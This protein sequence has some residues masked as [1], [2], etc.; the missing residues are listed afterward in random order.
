VTLVRDLYYSGSNIYF[1]GSNEI[2]KDDSFYPQLLTHELIHAFRD[3][4]ILAMDANWNY[5]PRLSGFEESFAQGVSY[6]C[7][8]RYVQLYPNDTVVNPASLYGS[9]MDWDY[10]YRNVTN[11]TTEDFW[12][13]YGGMALHWERYEMG[14]AA[15]R[16]MQLEDSGVFQKFNAAYYA[17]LNAHHTATPTRSLM[18][19]LL[20][21][22]LPQVEGIP[23]EDWINHQHIFDCRIEP[24]RKAWVRTQHYP[25][26]EYIIFQYVHYYETFSNGSDWAYY[27][28]NL[29][30]WVYYDLNGSPGNGVITDI[31]DSVIWQ[32]SKVIS[33]N[34]GGFGSVAASFTTDN[35]LAPWPGGDTADFV[36][37]MNPLGLY[38]LTF[39][40]DTTTVVVHRVIGNP[41]RGGSGI[42]GGILHSH[43][44]SV[45]IDHE[46][47]A[48]EPPISLVQGAFQGNRQW[49]SV[50]N[51]LTGGTDTKPGRL[52]VLYTDSVGNTFRTFRNIDWGSWKGNQ[53]FLFDVLE[54]QPC[55]GVEIFSNNMDDDCD[56]LTDESS[57][58]VLNLKVLLEGFYQGNGMM[59]PVLWMNGLSND[60]TVCDSLTVELHAAFP[61]YDLR[62]SSAGVVHTDGSGAFTFPPAT[63]NNSY[64]VV[65]KHRNSMETWSAGPVPFGAAEISY[66]FTDALS[67]AYGANST[68]LD[69]GHVGI[70]SGDVN[71]DGVVESQDY[72]D[73]E[74]AVTDIQLGYEPEDLTG[75]GVVESS[76][77]SLIENNVGA[78]IFV[79][80]P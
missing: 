30:G 34:P 46:G 38:T 49:A 64:Y 61:P 32:R 17:Y 76:D 52:T 19:S 55:F 16:K 44:G 59:T 29:P 78:I 8:N 9:S 41:L 27:D 65:A 48:P 56:G 31:N 75:D 23:T 54:M 43:G 40:F 35:D 18:I 66:D 47:Y 62:F 68:G 2:H 79:S 57:S 7:M 80:H 1:P 72:S 73:L 58:V 20:A 11:L 28:Y 60:P 3:D 74:N 42:F 33:N 77:Y 22:V 4:V 6:A 39:T 45:R 67:K 50:P 70:F 14:A 63:N 25:W 5:H 26:D 12:S 13:D 51:P 15:M 24:G 21:S 37:N 71:Q 53:V 69:M 36:L 10:D